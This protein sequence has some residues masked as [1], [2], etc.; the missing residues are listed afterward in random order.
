MPEP[1][2]QPPTNAQVRFPPPLVYLLPLAATWFLDPRWPLPLFGGEWQ[3]AG[4]VAG[5]ILVVVGAVVMAS[6]LTRFRRAGTSPVP[7]KPTTSLVFTGP[8]RRTRNP[9]YLGMMIAYLGGVLLLCSWWA[10]VFLPL[11]WWVMNRY[12]IARE[13]RYLDAA[14][15]DAYRSYRARV[16]RWV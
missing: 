5:V 10:V 12:V 4:N 3:R 13:E 16:R 14:F 1:T 15:G 11:V 8:Y 9:M 6:A 7:M 2:P